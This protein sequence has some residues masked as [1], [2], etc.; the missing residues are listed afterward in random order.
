[1]QLVKHIYWAKFIF[2]DSLENV[3]EKYVQ[4]N[5][6]DL[7]V[8]EVSTLSLNVQESSE[9]N[10]LV[11]RLKTAEGIIRKLYARSMELTDDNRRLCREN[12][13]MKDLLASYRAFVPAVHAE[14]DAGI[15]RPL[16]RSNDIAAF[17]ETGHDD[18]QVKA[19][20]SSHARPSSLGDEHC[21]HTGQVNERE[22]A[23]SAPLVQNPEM[24]DKS[25]N[26]AHT[27]HAYTAFEESVPLLCKDIPSDISS[28]MGLSGHDLAQELGES[29]RREALLRAQL[30]AHV[31]QARQLDMLVEDGQ[32][33]ASL[34]G[35][36][37]EKLLIARK[38]LRDLTNSS[39]LLQEE[40][41]TLR[42]QL[43]DRDELAKS[44]S[45]NC[46]RLHQKYHSTKR[47]ICGKRP[48]EGRPWLMA[49]FT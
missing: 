17:Q 35:R 30:Q 42:Q 6:G 16:T 7:H 47:P 38:L 2:G 21:G 24:P 5:A 33:L 46:Q 8:D 3:D 37:R 14:I 29:R 27:M 20:Y 23:T 40:N 22:R 18:D 11:E 26:H 25:Q 32:Q 49:V 12:S 10:A 36:D 45:A 19:E 15:K 43:A 39:Y 13:N 31:Q 1:M 4:D 9:K 34:D 44:R 28:W 41:A 48:L